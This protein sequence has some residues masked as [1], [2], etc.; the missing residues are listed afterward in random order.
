MGVLLHHSLMEATVH[1]EKPDPFHPTVEISAIYLFVKERFLF[2]KRSPHK[3]AGNCWGLPAGKLDPHESPLQAAQRELKEETGI[4]LPLQSLTPL[5]TLYVKRT[6]LD[7]LYHPFS[8]T[9][10][11]EPSVQLALDEHTAYRWVTVE[12]ARILPL[13]PGGEQALLLTMSGMK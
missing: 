7:F 3:L 5:K 12:E 8:A 6:D 2:L 9:L 4:F 11:E 10:E 1:R 13:V